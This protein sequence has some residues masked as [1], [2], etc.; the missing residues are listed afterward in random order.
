MAL[1]DEND[2]PN[3]SKFCYLQSLLE[4][5]AKSVIQGLS[6]TSDNYPVACKMLKERFGR[7]ERIIFA[8]IQALLNISLPGKTPNTKYV[9]SLWK[10]QD[11]LL[12]HVRSLEALGV[13]GAQYGVFMT[14]VILSR[15]PQDIR[16]EWSREGSGHENDL[17]WLLTFLQKGI[18]RRERSE[19]F[20]D[21][22]TG[23]KDNHTGE[24]EKKNKFQ[25][26][27]SA[28]QTSSE[29]SAHKCGLCDKGHKSENC[30]G[31][32]KLSHAER[33]DAIRTAKLH[34]RCLGEGHFSKGCKA[35]CVKCK[36]RHNV[37][38]CT[39]NKGDVGLQNKGQNI[40]NSTAGKV[41]DDNGNN[42]N[43]SQVGVSLCKFKP[44]TNVNVLTQSISVLQTAQ[45]KVCGK[46]GV[47]GATLLFDNGFDR[48]YVS[49]DFIKRVKPKWVSTECIS[50]SSFGDGKAKRGNQCN[51]YDMNLLD[52]NGKGHSLIAAEVP[53]ICAPLFRPCVPE[54]KL[55]PFPSLQLADDYFNNR[56]VNNDILVGLNAYWK[57]MWPNNVMKLE[58][59]VAQESVFGWVLSGSCTVPLSRE[60]VSS[61][62]LCINNVSESAL[63]NFWDLESVGISPKEPVSDDHGD[64]N[65]LKKFSEELRYFNG[66]YEVALPW[67]SDIAKQGLKNNEKLAQKRLESL[68]GKFNKNPSLRERY[69]EVFRV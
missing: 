51:I 19:A 12:T 35:K 60:S 58:N 32:L 8:H 57:F 66:R 39:G 43:V 29:V 69:D 55:K 26:T 24:S 33:E 47:Y 13:S 20:K 16:L 50:F 34:F 1:V 10:L 2:M 52:C 65:L 21:M 53:K 4:G 56:H 30:Y 41:G 42:E 46:G 31:I 14:P 61:Q 6:Q 45:V 3:I 18:E 23:K 62:L 59:L 11:D 44:N 64:S 37:L 28:L 25:S 40:N 36:G 54:E 38:C 67:K 9:S 22:N 7:S 48:S 63:H 27:A 5:E 15:L 68:D 49:S 17:A